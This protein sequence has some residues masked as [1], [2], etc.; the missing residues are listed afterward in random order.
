M[1]GRITLSKAILLAVKMRKP[2]AR[3]GHRKY[4]Y[5]VNAQDFF[6]FAEHASGGSRYPVFL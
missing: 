1:D 4:N 6:S 2:S 5:T 3:S